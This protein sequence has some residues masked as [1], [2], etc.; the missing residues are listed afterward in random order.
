[1]GWGGNLCFFG[2]DKAFYFCTKYDCT[3]L[4]CIAL[5]K[6]IYMCWDWKGPIKQEG[7]RESDRLRKQDVP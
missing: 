4:H 1:M 3:A 7:R 6:C 2:L 5:L